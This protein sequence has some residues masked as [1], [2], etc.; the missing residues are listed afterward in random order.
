MANETVPTGVA[1]ARPGN[2][3]LIFR[4]QLLEKVPYTY[5]TIWKMMCRGEFPRARELGGKAVD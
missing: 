3:K 2:V 4:P 1:P 5:V